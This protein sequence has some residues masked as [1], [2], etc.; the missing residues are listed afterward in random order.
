MYEPIRDTA[1]NVVHDGVR[2]VDGDLA[3][4]TLDDDPILPLGLH[5][6]LHPGEDRRVVAKDQV[7]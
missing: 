1:P 4:Q 3:L 2:G 6:T 7:R 5:K